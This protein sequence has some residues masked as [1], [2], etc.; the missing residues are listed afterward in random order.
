MAIRTE[1]HSEELDK[2]IETL[3]NERNDQSLYLERMNDVKFIYLTLCQNNPSVQENI[4]TFER[5]TNHTL[6]V[7]DIERLRRD[8]IEV[9]YKKTQPQNPLKYDYNPEIESIEL[10][11]EQLDI[12]KNYLKVSAP[13]ISYT[14]L[15]RPKTI[16]D[17]F[18]KYGFKLFFRNIRNPLIALNTIGK[19]NKH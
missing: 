9:H 8:F 16:H 1:P 13:F 19:L 6:E 7:I 10:E 2:Q 11:I 4:E 14:F 18:L 12:E 17:L 5:L 3:I 15:V